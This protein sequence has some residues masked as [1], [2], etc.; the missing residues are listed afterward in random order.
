MLVNIIHVC[1]IQKLLNGWTGCIVFHT[2]TARLPCYPLGGAIVGFNARLDAET[3]RSTA[4]V[5]MVCSTDLVGS[6]HRFARI[7][8]FAAI[9][10]RDSA[11]ANIIT[12]WLVI[13]ACAYCVCRAHSYYSLYFDL[14][15]D[16]SSES[17]QLLRTSN[18]WTIVNSTLCSRNVF[19]SVKAQVRKLNR[20]K[21]MINSNRSQGSGKEGIYTTR[22]IMQIKKLPYNDVTLT[23]L[24]LIAKHLSPENCSIG[25]LCVC[26]SSKGTI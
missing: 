17:L 7:I 4:K 13:S 19:D 3:R 20:N 5:V 6:D 26:V 2:A 16:L 18:R 14:S 22:I 21:L 9:V 8:L 15:Y 24:N 11:S 12:T 1:Q 25:Q 23:I 10:V